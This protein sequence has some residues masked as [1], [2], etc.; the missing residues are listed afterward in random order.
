MSEEGVERDDTAMIPYKVGEWLDR[1]GTLEEGQDQIVCRLDKL[2]EGQ[3]RLEEGQ[4]RIEKDVTTL[5][6]GV[7]AI[8]EHLGIEEEESTSKVGSAHPT[9]QGASQASMAAQSQE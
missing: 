2:E 8:K 9:R 5:K 7:K 1:V 3:K 4:C 6:E